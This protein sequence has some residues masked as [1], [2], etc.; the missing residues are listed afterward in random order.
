[1][2]P[3]GHKS[4]FRPFEDLKALLENKSIALKKAAA[5]SPSKSNPDRK[6]PAKD[7]TIFEEAM[8]DVVR[9]PR[10]S[11]AQQPFQKLPASVSD[12]N[13]ESDI[14][15]QLQELVRTGKGFVVAAT[16]EYIEGTGYRVNRAVAEKLHRGEFSIQAHIDLH[17]LNVETA[18]DAFGNFLKKASPTENVW[19]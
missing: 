14:L 8:A 7:Q 3:S 18:R 2:K 1:M 9:L 4:G 19:F 16:S 13:T 10:N 5:A 17:G 15:G 11:C 12:S 6:D